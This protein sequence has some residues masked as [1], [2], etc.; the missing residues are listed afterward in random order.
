MP[1]TQCRNRHV[2]EAASL[3][4]GREGVAQAPT[5]VAFDLR[6]EPGA[7]KPHAGICA[8]GGP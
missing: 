2:P 8:G 5:P 3:R 4:I 1:W 7:G 6:Q